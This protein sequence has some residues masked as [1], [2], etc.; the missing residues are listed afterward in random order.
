M[1]FILWSAYLKLQSFGDASSSQ[2][3]SPI[4]AISVGE[5]IDITRTE[6]NHPPDQESNKTKKL[7]GVFS[8][9]RMQY[10]LTVI[11]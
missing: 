8:E 2:G 9:K 4:W 1:F 3:Y 11:I 6:H 5:T 7:H 10:S